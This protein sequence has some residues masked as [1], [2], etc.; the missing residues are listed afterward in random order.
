MNQLNNYWLA[1][2]LTYFILDL[3]LGDNCPNPGSPGILQ[4]NS[5]IAAKLQKRHRGGMSNLYGVCGT[6]TIQYE[7]PVGFHIQTGPRGEK[8]NVTEY[9]TRTK[10]VPSCC[11]DYVLGKEDLCYP[12]CKGECNNGMCVE[13]WTC[14]CY[15]GFTLNKQGDCVLTCPCGCSNGECH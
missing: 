4:V 1:I 6:T 14:A 12:E 10:T 9:V 7:V 11:S 2:F 13:P 5:T 8:L 15:Q 3:G